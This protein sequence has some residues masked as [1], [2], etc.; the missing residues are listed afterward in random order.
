MEFVDLKTQYARY[1][2]EID[3]RIH[4]VLD[5]GRYIM[6]KEVEELEQ[7]LAEY[8][9]VGHCIGVSS[10]TDALLIALM[11]LGVGAGDEVITSAFSFFATGETIVLLGATPVF[12]DID[13][14]TYNM[15]PG[16]V[17]AA[18]TG[19]TK[20]IIPVSLFGQCADFDAINRVAGKQG[21]PV[22]EDGAQ[23]FGA[24]YDKG[25]S[26]A[27]STIGCT[28]FFPSKPLGCYGDG[29]ACFTDDD[30]L[31]AAM[32]SIRIHGQK[33]RYHHD[34]IGINGR[35]DTI[36][37]AVLL[38]KL[39]FFQDEVEQRQRVGE[40]YT[41]LLAGAD[42]VTPFVH[43]LCTSVFAQYTLLADNRDGLRQHLQTKGVPTAVH[44]PVPLYD[45]PALKADTLQL[46]VTESVAK[47]VVSLPMHPFLQKEEQERVVLAVKE[48]LL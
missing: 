44:Y 8:V 24:T 32:R 34:R 20:A 45:Q 39:D 42:V 6:G 30:A 26:C 12:V 11:A 5:H 2:S 33:E 4:A 9:G 43:P 40:R 28:S 35:L 22:V 1:K 46:P 14:E 19:R 36:Q 16:L 13:P 38:A 48:S 3:N 25:R 21:I 10:G 31:A 41:A 18:I 37:A 47:R 17:E 29:G 23:S 15:D 27:L 7:R